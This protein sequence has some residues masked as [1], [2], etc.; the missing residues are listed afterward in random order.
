MQAQRLNLLHKDP[1]TAPTAQGVL[2]I[3]ETGDR[4]DG[5]KTAHIKAFESTCDLMGQ[6]ATN[7]SMWYGE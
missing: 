5:H 4:K 1:T 3:D 7:E 6:E 2:G